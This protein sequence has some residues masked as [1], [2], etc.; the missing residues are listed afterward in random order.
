MKRKILGTFT[1]LIFGIFSL[2]FLTMAADD[3]NYLVFK[4]GMYSPESDDLEDLDN[5]FNGEIAFGHYLN[6]NF[7]VEAGIGYF[8]TD[9]CID[10]VDEVLGVWDADAEVYAIP[11][12]LSAIGISPLG[13]NIELF[14]KL[15]I[16]VY[17]V[18]GDLDICTVGG[19]IEFDDTDIAFGTHVGLGANIDITEN[20]FF[21]VEGKYI[22]VNSEFQDRSMGQ[23][24]EL[25][26][27][28]DGFTVTANIG[29]RF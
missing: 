29:L 24:I 21:G 1:L 12:T 19:D 23:K 8:E 13:D 25:D 20:M 14:G 7:A 11:L 18:D 28:L 9:D 17:Y 15:G 6:Q 16:G 2:P 27:D 5:G 22:W 4:G 26:S 3:S 10:G